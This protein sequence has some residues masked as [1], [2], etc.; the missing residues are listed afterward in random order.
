[1]SKKPIY[2]LND[3]F[4][5]GGL[6]DITYVYRDRLKLEQKL[7]RALAKPH[8][9]TS[10]TGTSK[11][12]KTVLLRNL[13]ERKN[14]VGV[15]GGQV[16][17]VKSLWLTVADRLAQPSSITTIV[18][19]SSGT[20]KTAKFGVS[21]KIPQLFTLNIAADHGTSKTSKTAVSTQVLVDLQN[22]CGDFL[23]QNDVILVIDD[24]HYIKRD[25]QT[26]I[27]RN[28]KNLVFNGLKVVL[29]SVPYRAYEAIQAE[30]E[31]TGRFVHVNVPDWDGTDLCE[32]AVKGFKALNVDFPKETTKLFACE[33]NGSPQLMQAFCWEA[34]LELEIVETRKRLFRVPKKWDPSNVFENIATD[35]GQPIYDKLASG[36]QSRS[37]RID[38]PLNTGE[39]VDIYQALLFAIAQTGPKKSLSYDEIRASL[40]T[41]LL[42]KVPQK[43]EVSNALNHLAKISKS[44]S[45][46]SRPMDWVENDLRLEIPD[47]MFRFFL[48]WRLTK[49]KAD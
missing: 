3:V 47:P 30:V 11:S 18:E 31:I 36:P 42:D 49:K 32:I 27:V 26:E 21:A 39:N 17:D 7:E 43:I 8:H 37:D 44:I 12:G 48:K 14:F 13:L 24:F 45:E 38:R 15:D 35:A 46:D 5:A 6:P 1:M 23:L 20:Q 28:L 29:L 33:A 16:K 41:A 25:E 22:K 10:I 9:F 4:V 19:G 40:S 34:C 2:R